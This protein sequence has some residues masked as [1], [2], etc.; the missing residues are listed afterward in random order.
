MNSPHSIPPFFNYLL[1]WKLFFAV[2]SMSPYRTGFHCPKKYHIITL[3]PS[4][5][6]FRNHPPPFLLWKMDVVLRRIWISVVVDAVLNPRRH[7]SC[8]AL[9]WSRVR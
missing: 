9:S 6:P 4:L 1:N 7:A 5:P 3:P 8:S 2:M